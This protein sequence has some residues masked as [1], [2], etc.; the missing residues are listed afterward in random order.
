MEMASIGFL[1]GA[2]CC[3]FGALVGR[4]SG[5]GDDKGKPDDDSDM[6]MYIPSRN[7]SGSG[8][9]G[10]VKRMD[11]EEVVA[12]LGSLRMALS[13]KEKEYLD[14]ACECVMTIKN[15]RGIVDERRNQDDNN[16]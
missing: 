15:L 10:N 9:N 12:G 5:D 14:Y 13:S 3:L 11:A 2:I 16:D 7:R 8:N 6:R 4:L 1:L